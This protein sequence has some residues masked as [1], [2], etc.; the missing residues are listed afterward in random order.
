MPSVSSSSWSHPQLASISGHF[1]FTNK[2]A[3]QNSIFSALALAS[4]ETTES[5][6]ICDRSPTN[7]PT[8]HNFVGSNSFLHTR[9]SN[10]SLKGILTFINEYNIII[11][12]KLLRY[13]KSCYQISNTKLY[14]FIISCDS[15]NFELSEKKYRNNYTEYYFS[16]YQIRCSLCSNSVQLIFSLIY[17]QMRLKC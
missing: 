13:N 6:M 7:F 11:T 3:E 1:S 10:S 5:Q 15:C 17:Q 16:F 4:Q 2:S 12:Y 14:I 8:N 9:S